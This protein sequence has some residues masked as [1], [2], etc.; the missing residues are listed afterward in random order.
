VSH[1]C[2]A[3]LPFPTS[4]CLSFIIHFIH[5]HSLSLPLTCTHTTHGLLSLFLFHLSLYTGIVAIIIKMI[6]FWNI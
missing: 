3:I 1:Q 4:F 6:I 2:P 5:T